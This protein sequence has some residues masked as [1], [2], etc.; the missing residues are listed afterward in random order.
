MEVDT[1]GAEPD[2]Q[3]QGEQVTSSSG[4]DSEADLE[5]EQHDQEPEATAAVPAR[6]RADGSQHWKPSKR[7][8]RTSPAHTALGTK[9]D[10]SRQPQLA[11]FPRQQRQTSSSR[12]GERHTVSDTA[13]PETIPS[14][15]SDEDENSFVVAAKAE[16]QRKRLKSDNGSGEASRG[17]NGKPSQ[18]DSLNSSDAV[19]GQ[20]RTR[21][22]GGLSLDGLHRSTF[23]VNAS[24]TAVSLQR[25]KRHEHGPPRSSVALNFTLQS[26]G[27]ASADQQSLVQAESLRIQANSLYRERRFRDALAMYTAALRAHPDDLEDFS[28]ASIL[29]NRA[30][31]YMSVGDYASALEDM[32]NALSYPSSDPSDDLKRLTRLGRCYLGLG[33][34][35]TADVQQIL[36]YMDEK[37]KFLNED[38]HK[39]LSQE[40]AR[41]SRDLDLAQR[42]FARLERNRE[43]SQWSQVLDDL[44]TLESLRG[45]RSGELPLEWVLMRAEA[46]SMLG[47]VDAAHD[48]I[49]CGWPIEICVR[50]NPADDPAHFQR[51]WLRTVRPDDPAAL[52]LLGMIAYGRGDLAEATRLLDQ[53]IVAG[54]APIQAE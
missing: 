54:Q 21:K 52:W 35:S 37:R 38:R 41:T 43:A 15:D 11:D 29:T 18:T 13:P 19:E 36:V 20:R 7:V 45:R 51:P 16:R 9:R 30:A 28:P 39:S 6:T 53:L 32:Q 17:W 34:V 50:R 44:Q 5:D 42:A 1:E 25:S 10:A 14:R 47:N 8:R 3:E 33:R 2:W 23:G 48:L 40:V 4:S 24:D 49:R 22:V 27:L 46:M 31:A 26:A 12:S